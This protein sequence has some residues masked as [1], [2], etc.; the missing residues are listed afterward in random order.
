MF[1]CPFRAGS[2]WAGPGRVS[3]GRARPDRTGPGRGETRLGHGVWPIGLIRIPSPCQRRPANWHRP[4]AGAAGEAAGPPAQ[5]ES[6]TVGDSMKSAIAPGAARPGGRRTRLRVRA[7]S[8]RDGAR[9]RSRAARARGAGTGIRHPSRSAAHPGVGYGAHVPAAEPAREL[10]L[11]MPGSAPWAGRRPGD[12]D[13]AAA[14][15]AATVP[16]CQWQ[17]PAAVGSGPDWGSEREWQDLTRPA[18]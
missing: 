7:P 14:A 5:S 9:T 8:G 16:D 6:R 2:V 13:R 4:G 12:A 18:A 1:N 17:G 3:P 11:H 15:P 10:R